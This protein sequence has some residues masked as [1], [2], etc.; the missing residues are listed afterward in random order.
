MYTTILYY[1]FSHLFVALHWIS[2]L[3]PRALESRKR[4]ST[5]TILPI[6]TRSMLLQI[7]TLVALCPKDLHLPLVTLSAVTLVYRCRYLPLS[8]DH[9]SERFSFLFIVESL[10]KL[11]FSGS[12]ASFRGPRDLWER[13]VLFLVAEVFPS[14]GSSF[15]GFLV[16]RYVTVSSKAVTC[17]YSTRCSIKGTRYKRGPNQR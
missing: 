5:S 7:T 9:G 4:C 10:W 15:Q 8:E 1:I 12:P 2:C 6:R 3:F 17:K 11:P 13:L 16:R 14:K